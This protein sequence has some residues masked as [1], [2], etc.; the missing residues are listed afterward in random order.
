MSRDLYFFALPL[1]ELP[2]VGINVLLQ[3]PVLALNQVIIGRNA[4]K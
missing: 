1:D 3:R 4:A 2:A